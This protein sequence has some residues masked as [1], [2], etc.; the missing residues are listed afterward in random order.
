MWKN[1]KRNSEHNGFLGGYLK[2]NTEDHVYV[3]FV[4][5]TDNDNNNGNDND[6]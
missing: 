2:K 6:E 5:Q 4:K 3:I 1:L